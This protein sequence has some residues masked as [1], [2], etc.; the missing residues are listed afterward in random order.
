MIADVLKTDI[1]AYGD[2]MRK[3]AL[4]CLAREGRVPAT[5]VAAY[6]SSILHLI[7]YTP[8]YLELAR[9]RAAELG[10]HELAAH[11]ES[12][13]R[14]ESGHDEWA[15]S[16]LAGVAR[17]FEISIPEAPLSA[18]DGLIAYLN[19]AIEDHPSRYLAYVL[20]AEYFTV[21]AGPE[22][23]TA[24]E[25]HCGVPASS[26]SVVA[27]HVELDQAHVAEG[28]AEIDNLVRD[29]ARLPAL[30]ETLYESMRF[31]S[32]FCDEL[33]AMSRHAA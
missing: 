24:L 18:M 4:L 22:W 15:R 19:E 17:S 30:R 11:F 29:P 32:G 16:D 28:L 33:A 23:I 6:L 2:R 14:Q 31:F 5:T 3:S 13:L 10:E 27:R 21:L 20:F 25:A 1:E 8:V 26:M 12:K 7:R 9:K